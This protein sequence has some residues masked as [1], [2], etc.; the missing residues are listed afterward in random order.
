M[1]F[2]NCLRRPRQKPKIFFN[3]VTIDS[4]T[5]VKSLTEITMVK[6]T[7]SQFVKSGELQAV[8]KKGFPAQVEAGSVKFSSS[9]EGVFTVEPDPDSEK[10]AVV[11]AVAPGAGTLTFEADADLGEGVKT[12]TGSV[13]IEVTGGEASGLALSFG[14][15]QEQEA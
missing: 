8:D 12:I 6:I 11:K 1:K 2:F 7:D 15:P 4:I 9:D 13:T 3:E 5:T 14:E 10:V